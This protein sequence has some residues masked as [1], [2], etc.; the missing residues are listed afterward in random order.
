[1]L[2]DQDAHT[3]HPTGPSDGPVGE[4]GT[5]QALPSDVFL[6]LARTLT[7]GRRRGYS[8]QGQPA[9]Q[10]RR[11]RQA[12]GRHRGRPRRRHRRSLNHTAGD[13]CTGPEDGGAIDASGEPSSIPV[14]GEKSTGV[15]C[16]TGGAGRL[17]AN[18][19]GSDKDDGDH[20]RRLCDDVLAHYERFGDAD[21]STLAFPMLG[22]GRAEPWT[23]HGLK[24]IFVH[25]CTVG[26][27][28]VMT[29]REFK[30][31]YNFTRKV[32][33]ATDAVRSRPFT[34]AFKTV[35]RFIAAVRRY[36]RTLITPLN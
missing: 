15:E 1:M 10:A 31:L 36:T 12:D 26:G 34:D 28:G 20:D 32:E 6:E 8:L 9:T 27:G 13:G 35:W 2:G 30:D 14:S 33:E 17:S 23:R 22:G 18:D 25:A 7:R 5:A 4:V 21:Q 19:S 16:S 3:S 11:A 24:H 29:R